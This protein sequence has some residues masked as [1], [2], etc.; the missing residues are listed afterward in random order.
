MSSVRT[1]LSIDYGLKRVGIAVGNTLTQ[2]AEPLEII[3]NNGDSSAVIRRIQQLIRDW[4]A[5]ALVL[6]MP[7]QPDGTAHTMTQV[8]TDFH[9]QLSAIISQPVYLIDERYSS[10]ILSNAVHTNS[11]GQTR[12]V[13]QDDRAA[14]VI[15]QQYLDELSTRP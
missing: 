8:C 3:A 14:A 13:A 5:D 10:A 12:A 7:C 1:I 9:T 2:H 11:R 15:L 6:G 4:Q